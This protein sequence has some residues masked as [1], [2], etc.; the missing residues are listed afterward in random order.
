MTTTAPLRRRRRHRVALRPARPTAVATPLRQN[1][2]TMGQH[3]SGL[4]AAARL[5]VRRNN[6]DFS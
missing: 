3:R 5:Q 2:K 1:L 6:T 4:P